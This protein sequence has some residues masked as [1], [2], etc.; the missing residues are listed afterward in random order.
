M[1]SRE[2]IYTAISRSKKKCI[3]V[4]QKK[5]LDKVILTGADDDSE[6]FNERISCLAELIDYS[7]SKISKNFA[8]TAERRLQ[9]A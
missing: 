1:L 3:C 6:A 7:V 2:I 9:N 5:L 4:G 8:D